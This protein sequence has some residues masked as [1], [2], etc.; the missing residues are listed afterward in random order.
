MVADVIMV[1]H[2]ITMSYNNGGSGLSGFG[3]FAPISLPS[4]M[5]KISL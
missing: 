2:K 1:S 3:D 5:A 4:K